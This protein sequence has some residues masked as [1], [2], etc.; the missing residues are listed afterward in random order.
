ME[1]TGSPLPGPLTQVHGDYGLGSARCPPRGRDYLNFITQ[2]SV[3]QM[4][5]GMCYTQGRPPCNKLLSVLYHDH[6]ILS[7]RI[8]TFTAIITMRH[9]VSFHSALLFLLLVERMKA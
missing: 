2:V 9:G 1:Q 6:T 8:S 7:N 4:T 5:W 3:V